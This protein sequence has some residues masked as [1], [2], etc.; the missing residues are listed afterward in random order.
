MTMV[1]TWQKLS[2]ACAGATVSALMM[3]QASHAAV[4]FFTDVNDFDAVTETTLVEDFEDFT[5]KDRLLPSFVSNNNTYTGLA[6]GPFP[7]VA[8]SSPG[9]RNYGVPITESSILTANGDEDFTVEFGTPTT[10]LGFDTY[11]NPFGP[12]TI[13]VFGSGGLLDSFV[14]QHDPT[15]VGFF[16]VLADENITSMRWTTTQGG[17]LNTGIDNIVQGTGIVQESVTEP[18]S[19]ISLLALGALGTISQGIKRKKQ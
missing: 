10:A 12:A 8:V 7:N 17:V 5:Q 9:Y 6:G 2:I 13:Q 19:V 15:Q 11:L 18:S 1:T 16:G 3:S 4:M 14:L